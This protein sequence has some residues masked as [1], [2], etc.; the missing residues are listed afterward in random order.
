MYTYYMC[1]IISCVLC[2]AFILKLLTQSFEIVVAIQYWKIQGKLKFNLLIWNLELTVG[3][4]WVCWYRC[5]FVSNI[6]YSYP[7]R[8]IY[9]YWKWLYR[10]YLQYQF[11]QMLWIFIR[12]LPVCVVFFI[13]LLQSHIKYLW[14]C[15]GYSVNSDAYMSCWVVLHHI[16]NLPKMF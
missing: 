1:N 12:C 3:R 9:S 7:V 10:F 15:Y 5:V 16:L 2:C 14:G 13:T 4:N 11:Y 6:F 8:F